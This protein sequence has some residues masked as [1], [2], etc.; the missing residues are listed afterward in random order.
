MTKRRRN[1]TS[2]PK[3][4]DTTDYS[5]AIKKIRLPGE[6]MEYIK[7]VFYGRSGTGKTTLACTFPGPILIL[8]IKEEG[9]DSVADLKDKVK[10]MPIDH[11]EEI[12]QIYWYLHSGDHPYKTVVIDTVTQ[13]QALKLTSL[14]ED[15]GKSADDLITKGMWGTTAGSINTWILNYRDLR[16]NVIFL[17]QD[18]T[19]KGDDAGDESDEQLDP[20]VGPAVMPS[21][22]KTLQA[23]VKTVGQTYIKEVIKRNKKG[24]TR[25]V[26]YRLRIGPHAYYAS[27]IRKPKKRVAPD[28]LVDPSYEKLMQVMK[29]E[30]KEDTPKKKKKKGKVNK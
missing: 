23:A 10:V 28:Y 8:D 15:M 27:K 11:W 13:Q 4:L 6:N 22:A 12:E 19:N 26:E 1:K 24:I 16:M 21:V 20:E 25:E 2:S 14:K 17:A 30:Y 9:D 5:D 7:A 3:K 29:G 18:R